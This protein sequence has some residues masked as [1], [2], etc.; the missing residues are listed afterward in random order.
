V[1]LRVRVRARIR[2]NVGI[3]IRVEVEI[4]ISLDKVRDKTALKTEKKVVSRSV[5]GL[6]RGSG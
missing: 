6:S 4:K 1:R 5:L 2:L 3:K